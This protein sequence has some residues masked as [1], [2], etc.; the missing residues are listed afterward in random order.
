MGEAAVSP[1]PGTPGVV[2]FRIDADEPG[3]ELYQRL[4][5]GVGVA[6]VEP[7]GTWTTFLVCAAPCDQT[8]DGRAGQHFFFGGEGF[9]N[10]STFRLDKQTGSITAH[11]RPAKTILRNL[12]LGFTFGGATAALGGGFAL[13]YGVL[14][15]NET[16]AVGGSISLGIGLAHLIPGILLLAMSGTRFTLGSGPVDAALLHF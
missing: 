6:A 13:G 3:V 7:E 10:S 14:K 5:P 4:A 8:I 11:V 16:I 12:G 15:S 2:R 9:S 1:P